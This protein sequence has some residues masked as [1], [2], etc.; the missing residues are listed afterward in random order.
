MAASTTSPA[1]LSNNTDANFRIWGSAV[2]ARLLASGLVKTSDTGQI[3]WTTVLAPT[4][5]NT[6]QGYEIWRFDDALQATAPVYIKFQFGSAA[7][8]ANP[9]LRVQF[10]SGSNGSGTLT[11]VASAEINCQANGNTGA[12]TAYWSGDT[13]RFAMCYG[14]STAQCLFFTMERSVDANGAVTAEAVLWMAKTSPTAGTSTTQQGSWNCTTGDNTTETNVG[15]LTPLAGPGTTS[16]QIAVY[17]VF[18]TKGVFL[19]PGYN[20][21]V[22][23]SAAITAGS[24][25]SIPIYGSNHTYMPIGTNGPIASSQVRSGAS[26]VAGMMRYE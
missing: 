10:G 15:A 26:L 21:L 20:I 12:G 24:S 2:A 17:P 8:V 18:H 19:Q 3:D 6:M 25:V 14:L 11:G 9:N 23:F 7:T 4:L 1:S 13:N 16:G 22:Y 5:A